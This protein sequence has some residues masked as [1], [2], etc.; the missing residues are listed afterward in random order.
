MTKTLT[1]AVLTVLALVLSACGSNGDDQAAAQSISDSIMKA[2]KSSSDSASQFFSMKRKD[3][4]CIGKGLVDKIGTDQL[5]K[6]GLLTK[7]NKTKGDVTQVKMSAGDAKQATDVL[8]GCTDVEGMM[9]TAMDKSG[10]VPKAMKACVTKTLNEKN[11]RGMFTS[12]FQGQQ[13]AAQKKLVTPM[14]K[15]ATGAQGQ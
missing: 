15:C 12:I 6:Y 5:K 11:L 10:S 9:Q 4:D 13:Q 2:Q 1:A 8:F 14:M 3:A 7:D